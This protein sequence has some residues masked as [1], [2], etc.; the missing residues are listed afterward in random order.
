[1]GK[2]QV[3]RCGPYPTLA[4]AIIGFGTPDPF[5]SSWS[6]VRNSCPD[7]LDRVRDLLRVFTLCTLS[8]NSHISLFLLSFFG[9]PI[10]IADQPPPGQPLSPL[11]I[12]GRGPQRPGPVT[13]LAIVFTGP[14][15]CSRFKRPFCSPIFWPVRP[16]ASPVFI[17]Q[18][19]PLFLLSVT[20]RRNSS[21]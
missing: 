10:F 2:L 4:T 8:L 11:L 19:Q 16:N 7:A 12:P 21:F 15:N 9:S 20:P 18:P 6:Q 17:F 14:L 5:S 1:V 13:F 3:A